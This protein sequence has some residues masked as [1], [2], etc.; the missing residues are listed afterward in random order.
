[1][2]TVREKLCYVQE[3]GHDFTE[4][5]CGA[6]LDFE[7]DDVELHFEDVGRVARAIPLGYYVYVIKC[8]CCNR[9]LEFNKE[10][11]K[12][13]FKTMTEKQFERSNEIGNEMRLLDEAKRKISNKRLRYV[14]LLDSGHVDA[15]QIPIIDTILKKHDLMIQEEI[16]NKI[17][18]LKN[19]IK[20]L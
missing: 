14:T 16:D 3:S 19:E 7:R 2:I 5:E 10:D 13:G 15:V 9:Y 18:E 8:P 12:N 1:M 4:C 17:N 6:F 11:I 20:S